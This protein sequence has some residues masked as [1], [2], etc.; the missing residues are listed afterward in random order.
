METKRI[1]WSRIWEIMERKGSKGEYL[2]FAIKYV[3]IST[4]EI[5]KYQHCTLT[6]IHSKG[7]TLNIMIIGETCPRTLKKC[8][9]VEF[10]NAKV[11]L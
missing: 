3:K 8:L 6:S 11:Y 1:H 5:R 9:I 4:G 7:D 10:N 2:P